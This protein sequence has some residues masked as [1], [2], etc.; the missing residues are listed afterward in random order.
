MPNKKENTTR[1]VST[2]GYCE[3]ILCAG[4]GG[5]GIMFLG[6]LIAH[7]G[8]VAGKNVTWMPSYGAEVRGGTAYSMTKISNSEIAN[9]TVTVPGILIA[10]NQPS[11]VKYEEKVRPGGIIILNR[12]LISIVP[13]RKDVTVKSAPMTDMATKLGDVKCANM[14]AM[15]ILTRRSKLVSIRGVIKALEDVFKNKEEL[16]LLNKSAIESGYKL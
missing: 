5:Q 9:P 1:K 16:F 11:F 7:A 8:L 10:M 3:E 2:A 6:K 14:I 15:G 4:F 13:K 12:S